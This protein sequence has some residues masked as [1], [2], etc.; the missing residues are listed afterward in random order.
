M[1]R[2]TKHAPC[3]TYKALQKRGEQVTLQVFTSSPPCARWH[4]QYLYQYN[5]I[6]AQRNRTAVIVHLLPASFTSLPARASRHFAGFLSEFFVTSTI[7]YRHA[8]AGH[9]TA[10]ATALLSMFNESLSTHETMS[11]RSGTKRTHTDPIRTPSTRA[12]H[13]ACATAFPPREVSRC[14]ALAQYSAVP[15]RGAATIAMQTSGCRLPVV[16]TA[17]REFLQLVQRSP[18]LR[19]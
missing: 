15:E 8:T 4:T 10:V 18:P 9:L 3:A 7:V 6:A 19:R 11:D 2:Q 17:T 13:L 1:L 5:F 12:L 14:S 16:A